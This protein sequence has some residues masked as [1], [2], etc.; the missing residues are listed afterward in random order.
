M[1]ISLQ[2][3]RE[4]NQAAY[5]GEYG[6]FYDASYVSTYNTAFEPLLQALLDAFKAGGLDELDTESDKAI[7]IKNTTVE[8]LE[9]SRLVCHVDHRDMAVEHGREE[10]CNDAFVDAVSTARERLS[11][12]SKQRK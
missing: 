3:Q 5:P 1:T 2:D 6:Q 8:K 4:A 10:G 11:A 12:A 9:F 7:S